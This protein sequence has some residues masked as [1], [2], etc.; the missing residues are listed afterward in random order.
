MKHKTVV[1]DGVVQTCCRQCDMHCGVN[2]HVKGGKIIKISGNSEHPEY[3]GRICPKATAAIDLVYHPD[4]L[5]Q[6][7]KKMPNGSFAE[8]SYQDA[9]DEISDKILGLKEKYGA[10]TLATWTGEAIGFSQQEEYS[11]RFIHA[12][13][14]PNFFSADSI[15][16]R[17]RYIATSLV[18]GY[19]NLHS[20]FENSK[21]TML[22]G[23]NPGISKPPIMKSIS[24]AQKKGGKLIVIDPRYTYAA[25][26][27]DLFVKIRPGTDGALAWGLARFIIESGCYDTEFVEK[28]SF[29]FEKFKDYADK[30]TPEY[31]SR[32]TGVDSRKIPEIAKLMIQSMPRMVSYTGI[33]LEHQINGVNNMRVIACLG[34]LCGAVDVEGGEV[35][36][37]SFKREKLDVYDDFPLK[38]QH[39]IGFENYPVYFDFSKQCHSL[40]GMDY[41]LGKGEYPLKGLI[42][43]GANPVLTNPNVKKVTNALANTELLVVRDLF[44]TKTAELA[45]Y[46]LP[47]ASFLERSELHTYGHLQ[48]VALSKKIF[49]I[50]GVKDEYSFWHDL[51]HRLGF[52]EAYFPWKNEEEVVDWILKPSGVTLETLKKYPQG[53]Q[54]DSFEYKKYQ[55]QPL[56]T[57]TGK[58]EFASQ[59]MADRG[60]FEIPEY[61]PPSYLKKTDAEFPFIL[62]T[63]A[64]KSVY[65]HSRFRNIKR[66]NSVIPIPEVEINRS[67]A[68]RIDVIDKEQVSIISKTGSLV[69]QA[70]IVEDENILP[71]FIQITHGWDN[72]NVNILTDDSGN[73]PISG[74]PNM[75]IVPTRI[76]RIKT[77]EKAN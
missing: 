21:L 1:Q 51:A 35:W 3:Q 32:Q 17:A 59:Y 26:K 9:L 47:A 65:Q 28:Y 23:T 5:L 46:V 13:G 44:L 20:D 22:W 74:F 68:E 69:I 40:T 4:R 42:I 15:C 10:G 62:I 60:C 16:Y 43:S 2:V 50:E 31:V 73:D 70:D 49:E 27:S 58:F 12:F 7:L 64:R 45:D 8:I 19:N 72:A 71:G 18:Q 41:M 54:Y 63:G 34:G 52:G 57:K 25:K 76:E 6:P 11:R 14:S 29:G 37:K 75:K 24:N 67:D 66:L 39:P 48:M 55:K 36:P 61:I 56:H 33:S 77:M 38:D 30:F 53:Y